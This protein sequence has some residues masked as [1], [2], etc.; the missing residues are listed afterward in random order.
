M[1]ELLLS[2]LPSAIAGAACGLVAW[3]GLRA[4]L[5]DLR[6]ELTRAHLRLDAIRAPNVTL[7]S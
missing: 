7:R 2:L 6:R 3:G 1:L 5:R 4:E